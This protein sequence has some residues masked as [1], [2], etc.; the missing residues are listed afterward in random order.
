M[1][2]N[3][4]AWLLLAVVQLSGGECY[5][6]RYGE[7]P[8]S[9][10]AVEPFAAQGGIFTL[11]IPQG[12]S[13]SEEGFM[14]SSPDA[15]TVG[16]RLKAPEDDSR[17][18]PEISVIYYEYGGFFAD[19]RDYIHLKRHSFDRQ[20]EDA[21]TVLQEVSAGGKNGVAFSIRTV[22]A[23]PAEPLFK[24]GIMYRLSGELMAKM[25][26]VIESF[27]VFPAKDGFFVFHYKASEASASKCEGVF[28][29]IV[30]SARFAG[31]GS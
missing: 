26:P 25:V 19:Y 16:I 29:R 23:R 27:R 24:P 2:L 21:K 18:S 30:K 8:I 5:I 4:V 10:T 6:A 17:I 1:K 31:E 15:K 11:S 14:Y 3:V 13:R 22:E 12:W 9:E 20:D 7:S 28:D